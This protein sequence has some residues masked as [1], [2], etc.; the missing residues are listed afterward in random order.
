M[1]KAPHQQ[2]KKLSGKE[3][4]E[5]VKRELE[6]WKAAY[7]AAHGGRAPGL[8]ALRADPRAEALF[9]EFSALNRRRW[10]EIDEAEQQLLQ[11]D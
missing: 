9:A 7:R 11:K 4:L 5:A 10:G 3:K 6:E 8:A 2:K 1:I